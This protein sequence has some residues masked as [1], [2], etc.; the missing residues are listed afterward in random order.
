MFHHQQLADL[1]PDNDLSG[2]LHTGTIKD[3]NR[4]HRYLGGCLLCRHRWPIPVAAGR[5]AGCLSMIVPVCA[6][7]T[8]H[9]S[10]YSNNGVSRTSL[11]HCPN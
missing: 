10:C 9:L 5:P 6:R 11:I 8:W 2:K 3:Q 1:P 7:R 4:I